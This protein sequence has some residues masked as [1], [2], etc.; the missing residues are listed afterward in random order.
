MCETLLLLKSIL[1]CS[2]PARP[3]IPGLFLPPYIFLSQLD[4]IKRLQL[5]VLVYWVLEAS[6]WWRSLLLLNCFLVLYLSQLKDIS[7]APNIRPPSD[8]QSL[9]S[10]FFFLLQL[11]ESTVSHSFSRHLSCYAVSPSRSRL[12]LRFASG[13]TD[14]FE[15]FWFYFCTS[16]NLHLLPPPP[17][18]NTGWPPHPQDN[19]CHLPDSCFSNVDRT[20]MTVKDILIVGLFLYN[21]TERYETNVISVCLFMYG[22]YLLR[23]VSIQCLVLW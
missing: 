14:C 11:I 20:G 10:F 12:S 21:D 23:G 15:L 18:C 4:R 5:L 17:P 16:G 22:Y 2:C 7:S 1:L 6:V 13:L 19:I 9:T 3:L 8:S